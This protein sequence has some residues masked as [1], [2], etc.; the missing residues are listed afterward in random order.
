MFIDSSN[1]LGR[2]QM[3]TYIEQREIKE[4]SPV[5]FWSNA[6][7]ASYCQNS[8]NHWQ[9]KTDKDRIMALLFFH[10]TDV[11]AEISFLETHSEHLRQGHMSDLFSHFALEQKKEIWVDVHEKNKEALDFYGQQGFKIVGQRKSYYRDGG[12]G[13]LMSYSV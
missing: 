12:T 8:Q 9:A 1:P 11:A 5:W 4:G 13:L 3:S 2:T 7:L 6:Q 10:Q